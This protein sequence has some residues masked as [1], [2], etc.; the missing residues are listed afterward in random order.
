MIGSVKTTWTLSAF[1]VLLYDAVMNVCALRQLP[2]ERRFP[3]V[4]PA[5]GLVICIG[6]AVWIVVR[7]LI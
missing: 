5:G 6:L 3:R 2:A 1:T 7:A 4:V